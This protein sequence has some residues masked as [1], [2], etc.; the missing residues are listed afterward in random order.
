MCVTSDAERKRGRELE[1]RTCQIGTA[2][3]KFRLN[4]SLPIVYKRCLFRGNPTATDTTMSDTQFATASIARDSVC[5]DNLRSGLA[6]IAVRSSRHLAA[7][8]SMVAQNQITRYAA[9]L[10]LTCTAVF[11]RWLLN[12]WFGDHVPFA[13]VYGAVV[14]SALC[15]GLGPSIA[16][17]ILGVACVR[18][19]FAPHLLRISGMKELSET[20]TYTG[21]CILVVAATEARHRSKTKLQIANRA[22]E[23]QAETLRGFNQQLE[24]RVRERTGELKQAE[25]SARQLGAQLLRMQD[26]ERRRI[27]RDLHDS[28]GQTVAIMNMNLGQLA[29][30]SNLNQRELAVAIDTKDLANDVSDQVR[31][32]SYLLHPPL[33]DDMGLPAALKWYVEGFSKRSG[34]RTHLEVSRHF[35]RLP[36]D[37]EIAIFRVVQ[38]ALTNIHRHAG[39]P[40]ATVRVVWNAAS[41]TV[42]IEDQGGGIPARTLRDFD[43]GAAMGV[44]L[45]G[46][47]ERVSQ[48]GGRLDLHSDERGTIV[49]AMFPL[50]ALDGIAIG[51]RASA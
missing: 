46:M 21:G 23:M 40:S 44:G 6:E 29:R 47:R 26:E 28:V 48:L 20:V 34:I 51:E 49:S 18:W 11:G 13:L 8:F 36:A 7:G 41:V 31:T 50:H 43:R 5:G 15:L 38:E 14:L 19:L 27:A 33:L 3:K 32:I 37:F 35:D 10:V 45:C 30:S 16:A 17:S 42:D 25:E 22:L 9:A 2:R 39:S 12:P 4:E 24:Q 1:N